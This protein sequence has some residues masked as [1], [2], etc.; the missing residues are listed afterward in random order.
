MAGDVSM[1]LG[2]MAIHDLAITYGIAV[3]RRDWELYRQVF[4]QDA[5]IDYSAAGGSSADIDTTLE[6]LPG[7]LSRYIGLQHNMTSHIAAI[8]GDEARACT[9]LSPFT[10][11]S[12]AALKSSSQ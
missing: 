8:V 11:I 2:R 7:S 6:W 1:L 5:V 9:Y 12:T 4:T 3:D 10:P